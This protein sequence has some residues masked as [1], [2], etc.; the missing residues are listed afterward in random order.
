MDIRY[1]AQ[2]RARESRQQFG[3]N[4]LIPVDIW[5]ILRA[6]GIAVI[7]RPLKSDISALFL[8]KFPAALVLVNSARTLGH[9]NFSGAH[10]YFHFRYDPEQKIKVCKVMEFDPRNPN[11]READLFAAY[12]LVPDEALEWQLERRLRGRQRHLSITDVIALEQLFWVS[13]REMLIRLEEIGY[14]N[15]KQREEMAAGIIETARRLGY[16]T[17]LYKPTNESV[18]LS[19]LPEKATLALEREL[20]SSGRYEEILLEAGYPELIYGEGEA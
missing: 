17:S 13:H 19:D 1:R 2:Q 5:Q 15:Q 4:Q 20:I 10:E 9:Q 12:F 3:Y 8:R 7:K 6:E 11:E 14:L 18:V 16:D